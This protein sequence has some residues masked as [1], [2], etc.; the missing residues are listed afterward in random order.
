MDEGIVQHC[1]LWDSMGIEHVLE[2]GLLL[3]DLVYL[4]KGQIKR[5][6]KVTQT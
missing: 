2:G 5:G 1:C 4:L 3:D 6:Y